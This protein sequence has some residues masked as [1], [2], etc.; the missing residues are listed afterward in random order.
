MCTRE[1]G[2]AH[3]IGSLYVVRGLFKFSLE[4]GVC[5]YCRL[6]FRICEQYSCCTC[7]MLLDDLTALS[8]VETFDMGAFGPA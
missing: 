8:A 1:D 6:E 2:D 7:L 5:S 3:K 4:F